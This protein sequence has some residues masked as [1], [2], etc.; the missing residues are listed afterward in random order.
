M[1][2]VMFFVSTIRCLIIELAVTP[3]GLARLPNSKLL[4]QVRNT[5]HPSRSGDIYV[6]QRP[7]CFNFDSGPVAGMHGSPWA[8]DTHVPIIFVGNRIGPQTIHRPV[9][10]ADLAPTLAALLGM[11]PPASAQG[12]PLAESA[13]SS[14]VRKEILR[15]VEKY[16][17]EES[18]KT[19]ASG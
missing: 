12:T 17:T 3:Q 8:Y 16:T 5:Y 11:S 2:V 18:E 7:Y 13:R 14:P 19:A 6:V 1:L 4:A 10:P 15:M 9:Q